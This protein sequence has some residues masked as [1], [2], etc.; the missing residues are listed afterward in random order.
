MMTNDRQQLTS[1]QL[2]LP[3]FIIWSCPLFKGHKCMIGIR[4]LR[5]SLFSNRSIDTEFYPI[6]S[7][8]RSRL[9]EYY[10]KMAGPNVSSMFKHL[11]TATEMGTTFIHSHTS[12]THILTFISHVVGIFPLGCW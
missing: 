12:C 5:F 9:C 2:F 3:L 7:Y 11:F 6:D 10:I 8:C 1:F 4:H